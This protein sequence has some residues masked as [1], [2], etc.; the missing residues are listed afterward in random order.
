MESLEGKM[1]A[2]YALFTCLQY[3]FPRASFPLI[4]EDDVVGVVVLNM[5]RLGFDPRLASKPCG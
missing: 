5:G 2:A 1:A 3:T 4:K